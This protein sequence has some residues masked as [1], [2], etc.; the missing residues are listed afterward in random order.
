MRLAATCRRPSPRSSPRAS[1]RW[2]LRPVLALRILPRL[3]AHH[4]I[5]P[6]EVMFRALVVVD[7]V[8][9]P[10]DDRRPL[11]AALLAVHD[12]LDVAMIRARDG[13]QERLHLR[14]L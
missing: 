4:A 8:A 10:G 7:P 5:A 1:R 12:L 9:K 13:S 11:H 2:S 6:V 14:H 3:R